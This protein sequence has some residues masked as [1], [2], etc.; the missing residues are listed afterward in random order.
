VRWATDIT[1][2]S[3]VSPAPVDILV[4]AGGVNGSPLSR[5]VAWLDKIKK[6]TIQCD[7]VFFAGNS[8]LHPIVSKY[9]PEAILCDN[10]IGEDLCWQGKPLSR[11][12]SEAYL[13][14]LVHHKGISGLQEFSEVPIMPTPA[15]V[16]KSYEAILSGHTHLDLPVPMLLLD[17]GGATTD[18]FYGG[19]LI[20][21]EEGHQ[22]LPSINRYV[23]TSFGFSVSRQSLLERLSL[24]NRLSDFLRALHPLDYE[25]FYLALREG[26][27]DWVT[28]E[29]LAEAACFLALTECTNGLAGGHRLELGRVAS[30]A[31]TGGAS[32][33]CR[34]NRIE[35]ICR[36]CGAKHATV[37]LDKEYRIWIEGMTQIKVKS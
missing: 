9:W 2:W 5:Q 11:V 23:F 24:S 12:L 18:V 21:D 13:L 1:N 19:E 32:Q 16:Q 8:A 4:I 34:T 22:P 6:L 29:F 7:A 35:R 10:V 14:D 20:A 36:I 31:I 33:I 30:I 27:D 28:E 3:K 26:A 37:Y 25:Y 15:V 17:I